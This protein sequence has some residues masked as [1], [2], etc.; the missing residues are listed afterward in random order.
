[1]RVEAGERAPMARLLTSL[2]LHGRI[3][4]E[5]VLHAESAAAVSPAA[6]R[7]ERG[8]GPCGLTSCVLPRASSPLE[9]AWVSDSSF[10]TCPCCECMWGRGVVARDRLPPRAFG[11]E[12]WPCEP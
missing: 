2:E 9:D 5:E 4:V 1:M 8:G 10:A 3:D 12:L 7:N 11:R 6:S